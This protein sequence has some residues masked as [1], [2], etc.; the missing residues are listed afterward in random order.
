MERWQKWAAQQG[1]ATPDDLPLALATEG[2][3]GPVIHATNRAARLSGMRVGERVVDMRAL[4][5]DL[6]VEQADLDGDRRA[7]E[8]LMLWTRRWCPWTVTDGA[9]GLILDTTGSA[10]LFGGEVALLRE[11]E[12]RLAGLG[13]SSQIA[14]APTW[15]AA[16][17]LARF[18]PVRAICAKGQE[19]EMLPPYPCAPC[20]WRRKPGCSCIAWG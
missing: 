11:M 8:R 18:G 14:M 7:L 16:W 20:G 2:A 12:E 13:L 4:C 1:S 6:Q 3:H 10:H 17:A 5:P 15:G 9:D 19:A